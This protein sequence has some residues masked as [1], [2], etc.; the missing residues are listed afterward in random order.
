MIE[1]CYSKKKVLFDGSKEVM[2]EFTIGYYDKRTHKLKE[3]TIKGTDLVEKDL[4]GNKN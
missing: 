4:F 1:A 3:I 2:C